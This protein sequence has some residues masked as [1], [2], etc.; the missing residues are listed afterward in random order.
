MTPM[1]F[2]S[3]TSPIVLGGPGTGGGGGGGGGLGGASA[4]IENFPFIEGT[5]TQDPSS[6][7]WAVS[8][9][10]CFVSLFNVS[11][12]KLLYWF[13]QCIPQSTGHQN[14][15]CAFWICSTNLATCQKIYEG[16]ILDGSA[17]QRHTFAT[18]LDISAGAI[19]AF[20]T[21]GALAGGTTGI[22]Y[23]KQHKMSPGDAVTGFPLNTAWLGTHVGGANTSYPN[24]SLPIC[25]DASNPK[26]YMSMY[27]KIGVW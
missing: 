11:S 25:P 13:E 24:S 21:D 6:D 9:D 19:L 15:N 23:V 27:A 26:Y 16:G 18:P 22:N 14:A 12:F 3:S 4:Q 10:L 20:A 17:P 2:S 7:L 5:W 1:D 8:P